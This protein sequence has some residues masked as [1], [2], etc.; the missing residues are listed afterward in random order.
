MSCRYSSTRRGTWRALPPD[1]PAHPPP[2]KCVL[3]LPY[4][5]GLGKF[6]LLNSTSPSCFGELILNSHAGK[7][8]YFLATHLSGS[9]APA[10]TTCAQHSRS[11]STPA[12]PYA[13]APGPGA[14]RSRRKASASPACSTS[15][16]S[17]GSKPARNVGRFRQAPTQ[18]EIE[19]TQSNIGQV[20][21]EYVGSSR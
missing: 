17:A 3:P 11:I 4:F 2:S 12:F 6:S 7:F 18:L 15:R 19:S 9:P 16:R 14:N 13:R 21:D 1:P 10:A 8:L 20:C 5:T